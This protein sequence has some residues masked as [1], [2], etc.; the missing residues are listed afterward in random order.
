MF[1]LFIDLKYAD[2]CL[3]GLTG[4]LPFFFL[5]SPSLLFLSL[6]SLK[7]LT[8]A[9]N[10]PGA[11]PGRGKPGLRGSRF[12]WLWMGVRSQLCSRG[13]PLWLGTPISYANVSP[14]IH[15]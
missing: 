15:I 9:G 8:A 5:L 4:P 11:H 1:C 3:Y 7:N 14:R 13:S 10:A 6:Y 12:R 2:E